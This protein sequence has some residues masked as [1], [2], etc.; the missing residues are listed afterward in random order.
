MANDDRNRE[1]AR[2]S[3]RSGREDESMQTPGARPRSGGMEP[4]QTEGGSRPGE[5]EMGERGR[6]EFGQGGSDASRRGSNPTS[7]EEENEEIEQ[8]GQE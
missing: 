3:G 5:S 7:G 2:N 4:G 1:S 8:P 6:S